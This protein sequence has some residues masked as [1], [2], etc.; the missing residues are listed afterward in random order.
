MIPP[1]T[2]RVRRRFEA[3]QTVRARPER[4]FP[5][6]CPVR[7]YDWIPE[8]D[9]RLVYSESGRA[10]PGCI[11]Q[12]DRDAEG[13]LDT[14]VI[15]RHEPNCHVAF[16]RVNAWRVMLYE[17][18]LAPADAERTRLTWRQT[19]TAV[20]EAG[21]E[22]VRGLHEDAF[23]AMIQKLESLLDHYLDRRD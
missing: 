10:E 5:L 14:W 20:N 16:V 18:D 12:T 11:F 9:C 22:H 3:R 17:I 2:R 21:D 23:A 13:G 6:L 7:E 15:S 19:I 4:V 8:W 1:E